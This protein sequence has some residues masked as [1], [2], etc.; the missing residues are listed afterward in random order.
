MASYI[1]IFRDL[2]KS[3]N[4]LDFLGEI[5][6]K[7]LHKLNLKTRIFNQNK[8]TAVAMHLIIYLYF[9]LIV[10]TSILTLF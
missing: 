4:N 3:L 9:E 7:L 2:V 1:H 5:I 6:N 8:I 10:V